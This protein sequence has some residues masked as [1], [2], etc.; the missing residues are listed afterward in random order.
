VAFDFLKKKKRGRPKKSE[1][2]G[3]RYKPKWWL[4]EIQRA[5]DVKEEWRKRFRVPLSYEYWEGIQRPQD[6]NAD[7]WITINLIYSSILAELPSLYSTDPY[8]YIKLA[9]SYSINPQDIA[10]YEK[11][12]KVRQSMLNYLKR[13][14]D[15]KTTS[16]LSIFDALFQFGITKVH[17]HADIVDNEKAGSPILDNMGGIMVDDDGEAMME[18]ETLPAGQAYR[19]SRIHPD[20]FFV[21]PDAGPLDS[22]VGWRCHRY[23]E[24]IEDFRDNKRYTEKARGVEGVQATEAKDESEKDRERRKKG[25]LATREAEN[26]AE[27][28]ILYE[29]WHDAHDE[30]FVV[31]EGYDD[32]VRKPADVP[33][34]T[35]EHPFVDLRYTLRDDSWYPLPPVSQL[36]DSQ[37]DYCFFRSKLS[38]HLKRFNRKYELDENAVDDFE[39]SAIALTLGDDGTVIRS[40]GQ[41]IPAVRPIQDAPLDQQLHT[42]LAYN[43]QDFTELAVGANQRGARSGVDSATEAGILE[44]RAMVREGDRLGLVV[45]FL[46]HIGR[47]LDQLVQK[48]IDADQAIKV[49]GPEAE[50]YWELVKTS[51]Y[52]QINGEY[53]YTINVGSVTPQLPEIERAQWT[54]FLTL[55]G[56]APFLATSKRLLEKGA[57]MFNINDEAMVEELHQIAMQQVQMQQQGAGPPGVGGG[58]SNPASAVGGGQGINNIRGGA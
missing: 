57:E 18:P 48:Y 15:L 27:Y 25:G 54:Q 36:L 17:Y 34:G 35:E 6:V 45:D 37:Y 33:P 32:F 9:R 26:K 39:E 53:E 42:N 38:S 52:D 22:D 29:M 58:V 31:A 46:Q 28:V 5:K 56:S 43:K 4:Q 20:D 13:E 12:A 14:I 1:T 16:R 41:G 51:D 7:E 8:F 55:L 21:D 50:A 23:R 19:V 47:K 44:K 40:R 2:S 11:K 30:W 3:D 24:H 49:T 10:L